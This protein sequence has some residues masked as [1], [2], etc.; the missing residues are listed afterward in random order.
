M[1]LTLISIEKA[2]FVKLAAEGEITNRD[3]LDAGKNPLEVVLGANWASNNISL[4]LDKIT[5]IDSSAIG[6]LIECQRRS[7]TAGGKLVLHSASPRVRDVFDLLKMRTVLNLVDN[8]PT[9]RKVFAGGD[10]K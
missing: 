6:W 10:A 4:A 5:F 1:K 8:E 2:G 3:F 7:K 9:A